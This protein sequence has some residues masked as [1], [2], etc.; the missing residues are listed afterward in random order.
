MFTDFDDITQLLWQASEKRKTCRITLSGEP[1]PRIINPYGIARTSRDQIVLVCWQ[2]L[3]M[4]KAGRGEGYRN[5]QLDRI[6]EVEM[7]DSPFQKSEDFNP[8]DVQ[9]K[10]WV[11]HI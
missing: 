5:L 1:F 10:E 3:G 9:Y 6:I 8:Q 4:T 2:S 11:Y 7:L